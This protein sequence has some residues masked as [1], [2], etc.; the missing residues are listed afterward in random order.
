MKSEPLLHT[1]EFAIRKSLEKLKTRDS[2]AAIVDLYIQPNPESG[3]VTIFDDEDN[4]LTKVAVPEWEES[5]EGMDSEKVLADC[6]DLLRP[7]MAAFREEG[8]FE[9]VNIMK[10]F[11]V[12]M[13]DEEM[14]V[15]AELLTIDDEELMLDDEF[16]KQ[17]EEELDVFYKQLM[18]D[19]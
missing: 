3:D 10:P 5:N 8:V 17:M 16:L 7:L 9:T 15:L 6:A 19:V 18:A 2:S 4:V 1:L 14:E 11:S 12:I 13:V